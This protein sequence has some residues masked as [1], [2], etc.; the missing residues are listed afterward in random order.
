MLASL[1]TTEIHYTVSENLFR[2]QRQRIANR[3]KGA[4]LPMAEDYDGGVT[5]S[6]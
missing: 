4:G 6:L 5:R 2:Q 1:P 3:A